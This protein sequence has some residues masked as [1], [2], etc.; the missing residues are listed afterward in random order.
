ML[1][2]LKRSKDVYSEWIQSIYCDLYMHSI[3]ISNNTCV[4]KL[5][6]TLIILNPS[7]SYSELDQDNLPNRQLGS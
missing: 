4:Q 3:S 5:P 7:P 6:P 2:K 1:T